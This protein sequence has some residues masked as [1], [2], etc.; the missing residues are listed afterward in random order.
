VPH[1]LALD[2][3]F[4]SPEKRLNAQSLGN[5]PANP[6]FGSRFTSFITLAVSAMICVPDTR[7]GNQSSRAKLSSGSR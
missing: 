5:G 7:R 6:L 4:S 3:I 1:R 2:D